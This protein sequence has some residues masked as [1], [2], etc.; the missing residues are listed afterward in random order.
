MKSYRIQMPDKLNQFFEQA[1]NA[2]ER[3]GFMKV[4]RDFWQDL[5]REA[6][7]R[8]GKTTC[9]EQ[10]KCAAQS[11]FNNQIREG[12]ESEEIEMNPAAWSELK[13]DLRKQ[14]GKST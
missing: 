12:L 1:L 5:R 13:D 2:G 4:D 10:Q 14:L 8:V 6:R 7:L 11:K 9:H 3:S